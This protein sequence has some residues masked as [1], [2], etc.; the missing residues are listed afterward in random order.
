MFLSRFNLH[1]PNT[2]RFKANIHERDTVQRLAESATLKSEHVHRGDSLCL[3]TLS[4]L[5]L[6]EVLCKKDNGGI[7][8]LPAA[9]GSSVDSD[10]DQIWQIQRKMSIQT[11]LQG[12]S[13]RSHCGFI[14][15]NLMVYLL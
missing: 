8:H 13:V 1:S 4:D 5:P 11:P 14:I 2:T 12:H 10:T 15:L 7:V 3:C 9:D 6:S